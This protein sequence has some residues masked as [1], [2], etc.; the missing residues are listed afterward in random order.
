MEENL[1]PAQFDASASELLPQV[2]EDL[3]HLARR[4]VAANAQQTLTA[5][6]LVHEAWMRV[7]KDREPRWENRRHFFGAAAQ[8]MRR[9]LLN[10]A[11][12]KHR[13]K[14]G[15]N[16]EHVVLDDVEIAAPA[17]EEELL[18][19]DEALDRLAME[20][21]FLAEIVGLYYFTGL[22]WPEIAEMTGVSERELN[23]QWTFARAWLRTELT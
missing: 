22:K 5:T 18:A 12:D 1:P 23:R 7:A 3:R 10:R 17:P 15:G 19:L 16:H 13:L 6:A 21:P 11:R 8:A 20:D 14:R 9:I 4:M 2:Y